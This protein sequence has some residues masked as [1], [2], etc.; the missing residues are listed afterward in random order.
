M[1]CLAPHAVDERHTDLAET[2]RALRQKCSSRIISTYT[3]EQQPMP[4]R[5]NLWT[6][7]DDAELARLAEYGSPKDQIAQRL[8]RTIAA[9]E[10]RAAKLGIRMVGTPLAKRRR[11]CSNPSEPT[12]AVI[13]RRSDP[14]P[15]SNRR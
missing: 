7:E 6:Q 1:T 8:V 13:D 15:R 11:P 12:A 5:K 4:V 14:T 9:V 10:S 2:R 3:S